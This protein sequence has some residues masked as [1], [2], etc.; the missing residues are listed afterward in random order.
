MGDYFRIIRSE[1]IKQHKNTIRSRFTYF[2][3]LIWPVISFINAYYTYKPFSI[4]SSSV[5]FL[6]SS[7]SLTLFL[8]IGYL[9]YE[10]F[11]SLVRSALQMSQERQDGTLEMLFLSPANKIACIYGRVL[12]SLF[13]NMWMFLCFFIL[14]VVS[15]KGISLS[16]LIYLPLCFLV[17]ILG[18]A[19]WGGIMNVIFLF[20]RDAS[21]V[22][23]LFNEPMHLLSGVRIPVSVFPLWAKVLSVCL[24]LTHTLSILRSLLING[25]L[26]SSLTS[27]VYW[28]FSIII[29]VILTIILLRVA[30]KNARES[31]NL[32]F[33]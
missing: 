29:M 26:R 31:G 4:Q 27:L 10:C 25:S 3:L 8:I 30:E 33:F 12:G 17:V 13:Q 9:G 5:S 7:S 32:N 20:S 14:I 15:V 21:I 23:S 6:N 1:I 24:P 28:L 16:N 18:A 2:T 22:F 19:A 11:W